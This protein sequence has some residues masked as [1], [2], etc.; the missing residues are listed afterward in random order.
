M[1][2]KP[3]RALIN[4]KG[5]ADLLPQRAGPRREEFAVLTPLTAFGTNPGELAAWNY[6]PPGLPPGAP[7]V[8]VLHGCTQTA[9]AY[10]LGA[11][12]STLARRHGFAL[13]YP[14]QVRANN[15][16]L[17]FN[18]FQPADVARHGGEAE[19]IAQ[20]TAYIV[21][22]HN[23]SPARVGITGLSAGGAMTAAMLATYPDLFQAGAIIAGLPFGSAR[24][25]NEAFGAMSGRVT[26]TAAAWGALVRSAGPSAT[27]TWPAVQIWQGTADTTVRP[28]NGDELVKQWTD[29]HALPSSPNEQGIVDGV[30]HTVW[31]K[32]GRPSV[33][34][35]SVPGMQHGTPLNTRAAQ[36][37]QAA[38]RAGPHMLEAGISASYHIARGWGLLTQ[39]TTAAT[40]GQRATASVSALAPDAAPAAVVAAVLRKAGLL[41]GL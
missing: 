13:L 8:V 35:Y 1:S 17:C 25:M 14:E 27:K 3:L 10:D 21:R 32:N 5:I 22:A 24:G 12:W 28:S 33:E 39:A 16:N 29:V 26:Q 4:Q 7:L 19:S 6:V 11:G 37:D 20:A 2:L 38:G 40:P 9:A 15:A 31:M 36:A 23:L 41:K 34:L 30:A 18:W